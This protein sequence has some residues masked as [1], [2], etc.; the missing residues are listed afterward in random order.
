MRH[1]SARF[2]RKASAA[3]SHV[4]TVLKLLQ[5]LA[6]RNLCPDCAGPSWPVKMA[7]TL[8]RNIKRLEG[9]TVQ[10]PQPIIALVAIN[11][12]DKAQRDVAVVSVLPPGTG[13]PLHRVEQRLLSR[14]WQSVQR[15]GGART[16][17]P[18]AMDCAVMVDRDQ[19]M[20]VRC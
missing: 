10:R 13:D 1:E 4:D 18:L 12:A 16:C 9:N 15:K 14:F 3:A 17:A 11:C 7:D 20:A 5:M 2:G 6:G 8:Q 19:S